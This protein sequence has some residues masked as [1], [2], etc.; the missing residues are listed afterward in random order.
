[1]VT[2]SLSNILCEVFFMNIFK[3]L[4]RGYFIGAILY[5]VLG[6]ILLFFP[7]TTLLTICYAIAAILGIVGIGY[8]IAYIKSDILRNYQQNNL[9]VG[10]T[11]SVIAVF[12]LLK[13]ELIISL[14][15][16]FLGLAIIISSIIKLQHALDLMRVKFA[17]WWGV[18]LIALSS[19]VFGLVLIAYP[20]AAATTMVRMI[21]ISTIWSGLTDIAT[22]VLFLRKIK[23]A[24][25]VM[26]A[27]DGEAREID[28]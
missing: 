22:G 13:T 20:F 12:I 1:M 26:N 4:K 28:S 10:L 23:E 8:I 24:K 3:E 11:F 19:A 25:Q 7:Q 21:G 18:L 2:Q 27:V 5:I 15:P 14:L 9:V 6:V 17:G 16:I